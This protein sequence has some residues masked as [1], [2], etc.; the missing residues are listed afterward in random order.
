HNWM[1]LTFGDEDYF[2][3]STIKNN[4]I[5]ESIPKVFRRTFSV[6]SINNKSY[7]YEDVISEY[8][9]TVDVEVPIIFNV[10]KKG[11]R[12][13]VY[14]FDVSRQ[15]YEVAEGHVDE[16]NL[17]LEKLGTNVLYLAGFY[18]TSGK[19]NAV[20]YPFFVGL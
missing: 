16:D 19:L 3:S 2:E 10:P 8:K 1:K 20:N 17:I 5:N 15:W 4:Y 7:L 6:N 12:P 11:D 18:D 9:E 13:V 14:I